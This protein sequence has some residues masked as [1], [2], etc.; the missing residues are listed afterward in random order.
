[1]ILAMS[2]EYRSHASKGLSKL[3]EILLKATFFV[4][5]VCC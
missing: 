5:I 2:H 1:L 4:A 3:H